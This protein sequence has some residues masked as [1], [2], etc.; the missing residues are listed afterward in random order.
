MKEKLLK[1]IGSFP[2]AFAGIARTVRR[3]RNMRIHLCAVA[4]VVV[5]GIWQGLSAAHWAVELLCCGV[6]IGLEMLNSALEALCDRVDQ[7]DDPLIRR[8]KDA[9][10]GAVLAAALFSVLIW[11]VLLLWEREY[12]LH[13]RAW[14]RYGGWTM[15]VIW[16]ACSFI[17]VFV[18]DDK[19]RKPDADE[20]ADGTE[21]EK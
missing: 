8:C 9:A 14:F 19:K 3:E 16:A 12:L 6:V 11:V 10:A 13:F 1:L 4:F 17:I 5:T 21:E 18:P 7:R 2:P 20:K 15:A